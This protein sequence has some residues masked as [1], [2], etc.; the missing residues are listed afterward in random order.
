MIGQ[1][2]E[3]HTSSVTSVAA[4]YSVATETIS[5]TVAS[6]SSDSTVMIWL[7]ENVAGIWYEL[8]GFINACYLIRTICSAANYFIW[9]RLHHGT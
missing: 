8:Y 2:L 9:S 4:T 5:T 7:R 6:A 3:G 1:T